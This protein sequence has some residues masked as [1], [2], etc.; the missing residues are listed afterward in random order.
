[1]LVKE[2][3]NKGRITENEINEARRR[4]TQKA[5]YERHAEDIEVFINLKGKNMSDLEI[6]K[7][8]GRNREYIKYIKSIATREG[9]WNKSE[10]EDKKR[11]KQ[12]AE[13]EAFKSLYSK[14]Y[15]GREIATQMGCSEIKA[16]NIERKAKELNMWFTPAEEEEIK[17]KRSF[18]RVGKQFDEIKKLAER[19][20]NT[21]QIAQLLSINESTVYDIINRGK[22]V[23][24]WLD[25]SSLRK[26][27]RK[28][29]K[30]FDDRIARIKS[31]TIEGH[32]ID[33]IAEIIKKSKSYVCT[34][35]RI[36]KDS[37][38][39]LS[40]EEKK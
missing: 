13:I 39:W 31:L 15:S 22:E 6:G 3:I 1:M 8:M 37:G 12:V 26:N 40:E 36:A 4:K 18:K 17:R 29:Q 23:G 28:K 35:I 2:L 33:Q 30:S 9:T 27:E 14:G 20:L 32:T 16:K 34:T 19:G 7:T 5:V 38:M 21:K 11:E 24:L 10:S 25:D